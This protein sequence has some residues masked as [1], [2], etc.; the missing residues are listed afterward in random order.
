MARGLGQ[1]DQLFGVGQSSPFALQRLILARLERGS[2]DL[3]YLKG[4]QIHPPRQLA[5]IPPQVG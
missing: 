5:L 2:V 1:A 3:L 4:E